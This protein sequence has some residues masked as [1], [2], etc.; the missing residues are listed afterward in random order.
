MLL[1]RHNYVIHYNEM[2]VNYQG[3]IYNKT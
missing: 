3:N 2:E 1:D